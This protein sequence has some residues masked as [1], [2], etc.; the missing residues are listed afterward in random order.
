MASQRRYSK[1]FVEHT[2]YRRGPSRAPNDWIRIGVN[3]LAA[4]G[5]PTQSID[6]QCNEWVDRTGAILLNAGAPSLVKTLEEKGTVTIY[7]ILV[8]YIY[9][10]GS[11]DGKPPESTPT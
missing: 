3:E 9:E 11:T 4:A 6:D 10:L 1:T 7:T 5:I 8:T 2:Y